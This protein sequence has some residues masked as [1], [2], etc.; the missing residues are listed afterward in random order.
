ML[1][2]SS[3]DRQ[4]P[5]F[6]R[7]LYIR[8]AD[9]FVILITST[10]REA[11]NIKRHVKDFLSREIGLELSVE[12]TLIT[13]TRKPFLFLGA[14]CKRVSRSGKIT[15]MKNA[16]S[17]RTTPKMRIDIPIKVLMDKF[18]KNKFCSKADSPTARKDLINLDH[19]DIIMFY[20]SRISGLVEFYNFARNYAALHRFI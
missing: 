4:D 19:P 3:V 18:I 9:D 10:Y 11:L 13:P 7:I 8:Y 12:K 15:R 5:H 14:T 6:R 17:R 20:N 2:I 16:I 1:A